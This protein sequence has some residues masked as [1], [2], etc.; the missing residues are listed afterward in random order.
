MGVEKAKARVYDH[1]AML[2]LYRQDLSDPEIARR[3]GCTA[4]N[5]YK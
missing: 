3:V 4:S 1:G 2:E 5:V